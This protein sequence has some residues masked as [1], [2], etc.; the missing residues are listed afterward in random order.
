MKWSK[1]INATAW[2]GCALLIYVYIFFICSRNYWCQINSILSMESNQG[3]LSFNKTVHYFITEQNS[4]SLQR[5]RIN[6]TGSN[7][8]YNILDMTRK[9]G[10]RKCAVDF[11]TVFKLFQV[12]A[13]LLW[14]Y[15]QI[16]IYLLLI[17]I[18]S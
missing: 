17:G 7:H 5:W 12:K 15:L 4:P 13:Q 8:V 16:V 11:C 1:I 6:S 18:S 3:I 2:T 14:I 9:I 10:T